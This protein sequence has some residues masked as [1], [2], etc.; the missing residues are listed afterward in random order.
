M[1]IA[2]RL[3]E[4]WAR[5]LSSPALVVYMDR[6]RENLRRTLE[7]VGGPDRWR[8]HVKTTK[9]PEVYAEM[10]RSGLRHFKCATLRE[11]RVLARVFEQERLE[12]GDV[13]LA[14]PL[15]GPNLRR[16][17]ELA[18]EKPSI[19]FSVL[20]EDVDQIAH[21]DER[22]RIFVDVNPGMHRTGIPV[23]AAGQIRA[24]ARA[25][26]KRFRG[27][28]YYDGHIH[29]ASAE[30]RR[31]SAWRG[32]ES[33]LGLMQDLGPTV[34]VDEIVTSGTPA[35]RYALDFA[36]FRDLSP[37][38][39][40]VSPGTVVFH[41][42]RSE[43]DLDDLDLLPAALV[44]SRVVSHP[45]DDRF[46]CDAGSKSIAADAGDPCAFALGH[47]ETEALAPSEEHL[48]FSCTGDLPPRGTELYLVPRHV[49]P[50]VNLAE[51]AL[52]VDGDRIAA[53]CVEARAHD[54]LFDAP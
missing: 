32:Y 8:P 43:Q 23:G 18:R 31:I 52:L 11:A 40:R 53:A 9:I 44:F 1:A 25:A 50:T 49:C 33:L 16:L 28:H 5:R 27:V 7:I 41:D 15:V 22:L 29:E 26:G 45:R 12:N 35:F 47:P 3:A 36:P 10:V 21:I 13:L 2:E 48:S 4:H 39:H 51:Q 34:T 37:A 54:L 46:T 19:R 24:L 42:L 14:Y 30:G 20:C 38:V 6:V 17:N